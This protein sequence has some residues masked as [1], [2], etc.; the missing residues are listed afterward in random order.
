MRP[1]KMD[2]R[3]LMRFQPGYETALPAK[4]A[5]DW[6]EWGSFGGAIEMCNNNGTC[7]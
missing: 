4:P 3:T 6:S 7:R 2:D 1:L 5:L